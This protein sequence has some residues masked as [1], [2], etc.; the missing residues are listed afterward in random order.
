MDPNG[1]IGVNG[2]MPW[3]YKADFKRFKERTMGGTLI[4]GKATWESLPKPLPGRRQ[5]VLTR[6]PN[7]SSKHPLDACEYFSDPNVALLAAAS[8]QHGMN[9]DIWIAGGAEVYRLFLSKFEVQEID[10]TLVPEAVIPEGASVTYWPTSFERGQIP[11][12]EFN[13]FRT[14]PEDPRLEHRIYTRVFA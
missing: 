11:G 14:N 9:G 4:M 8:D 3:H 10:L 13:A 2:T 7:P 12:F 6:Q 1:V 5:I